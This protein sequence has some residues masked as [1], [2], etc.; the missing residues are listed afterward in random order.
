MRLRRST[1]YGHIQAVGV[2]AAGRRQYLYHEQWRRE[3]DEEKFDRMLEVAAQLPS[4]REQVG[5]DLRH[6]AWITVATIR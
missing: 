6:P 1:P 5:A 4:L 3:R 2:D